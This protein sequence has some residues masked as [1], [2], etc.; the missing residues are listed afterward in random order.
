MRNP[1]VLIV[2]GMILLS[3][4]LYASAGEIHQ[5]IVG[6]DVEQVGKLLKANP[7]LANQPDETDQYNS[8]PLHIAAREGQV[9]AARLLLK[10]GAALECGDSDETTPL[11][12]AAI[13]RRREMVSFLLSQGADV[14]RR[15]KNG[16]YALSFAAS[17]GDTVTVDEI[18]DAGADLNFWNR[19]GVTLLHYASSRGLDRLFNLLVER[20]DDVNA[21]TED[22]MTPLHWAALRGN[23]V[24]TEALLARGA[25]PSARSE[26]GETPLINAAFGGNVEAGRV[27]L[28]HGADVNEVSNQGH[29]PLLGAAWQGHAEFAKLAIEHGAD[30]DYQPEDGDNVLMRAIT[31]GDSEVVGALCGAG[32]NTNVCDSHYGCSALHM[33]TIQGDAATVEHL[34]KGGAS[35]KSKDDAGNTPLEMAARY[36]HNDV[37]ELLIAH[38]ADR[39]SM[40]PTSGTLPAQGELAEGEAVIWY[41]GHSGWALKTRNHFLVFDY[42]DQGN[43]PSQPALCN[44]NINP[45]EL[46]G[47]T[48]TVFASHEHGDHYDPMI[49]DWRETLPNVTYVLGCEP[50]DTPAP[51]EYAAPR[52]SRTINGMKVSTIESNDT[53]VGFIVEVDGLVIFHAGDHANRQRDFSGPYQAEIDHLA[54]GGMKPDIAFMPVSGCGFGDQEAVKLGVHYALGTL[55]PS[56]FIPMHGGRNSYR[57][58]EFIGDCMDKFTNVQMEA[59]RNRG[60]HFRYRDGRMS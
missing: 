6:G 21:V 29:T 50:E 7:E 40:E 34:L 55:K 48:V 30:V 8:L 42:F 4:V 46:A 57:Y 36:G 31:G 53:G 18:L 5:A 45:V 37:A 24:T 33:A 47:E 13:Y 26:Q 2:A 56:V 41:L 32:V 9:E 43:E 27:L 54:A 14:N 19:Q 51:Y 49:F 3:L 59:P 25:D 10:A 60:D 15:D 44:G 16:A 17:A 39:A 11:G 12:V 38:G 58:H 35:V 1:L 23:A 20:G 52:T 28:S 22:G